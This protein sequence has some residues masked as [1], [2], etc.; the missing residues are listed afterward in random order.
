MSRTALQRFV[1]DGVNDGLCW[2]KDKGN[3]DFNVGLC[4]GQLGV[5]LVHAMDDKNRPLFHPFRPGS[6][7]INVYYEI[8]PHWLKNYSVVEPQFVCLVS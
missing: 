1:E 2:Q 7:L 8:I 3:E 4:L 5:N 6:V